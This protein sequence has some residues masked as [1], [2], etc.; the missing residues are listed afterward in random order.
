MKNDP[1]EKVRDEVDES[2]QRLTNEVL[3]HN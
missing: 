3:K 2:L 1:S